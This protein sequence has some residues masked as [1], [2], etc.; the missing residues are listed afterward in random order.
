MIVLLTLTTRIVVMLMAL[1][2]RIMVKL[3][4]FMLP[5]AAFPIPSSL[6]TEWEV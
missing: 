1:T 4:D 2:I 5:H 6:P 3:L